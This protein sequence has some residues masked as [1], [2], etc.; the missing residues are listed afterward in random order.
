MPPPAIIV[1][2]SP[3]GIIVAG[4]RRPAARGAERPVAPCPD[5]FDQGHHRRH[6]AELSDHRVEPLEARALAAEDRLIRGTKCVDRTPVEAA[7]LQP[8]D[9]EAAEPSP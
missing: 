9:V 3:S 8:N 5:E 1:S 7:P 2:A 4:A 6:F